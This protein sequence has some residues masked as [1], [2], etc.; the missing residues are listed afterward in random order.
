MKDVGVDEYSWALAKQ[1]NTQ[2]KP[3]CLTDVHKIY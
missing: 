3:L 2:S 1:G